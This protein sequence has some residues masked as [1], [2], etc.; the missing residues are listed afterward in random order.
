MLILLDEVY[1]NNWAEKAIVF[2]GYFKNQIVSPLGLSESALRSMHREIKGRPDRPLGDWKDLRASL[3]GTASNSGIALQV[4]PPGDLSQNL[5][6]AV[7]NIPRTPNRGKSYHLNNGL[8]TPMESPST[9][10]YSSIRELPRLGF[11]AFDYTNQG[12]NSATHFRA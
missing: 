8:L 6:T 3:E 2:S 10:R 1:E 9:R 12:V 7:G 11:R 4:K 5:G